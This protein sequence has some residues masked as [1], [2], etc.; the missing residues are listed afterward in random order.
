MEKKQYM[1]AGK[2]I[3]THG[4]KG[5][6]KIE[7]WLDSPEFFSSFPRLFSKGKEVKILS[8]R[9]HKGFVIARLEGIDDMNKAMEL[10]NTVVSIARTDAHLPE[11]AYFLADIIGAKVIDESGQEIGILSDIEE[12]PSSPLYVVSGGQDREEHLI[13]AVPEFIKAVDVENGV[14]TVHLIEGM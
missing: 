4:V 12:T 1:E 9:V 13:P 2:I 3:N 8:A 10:K 7:S 5:E 11:G 14:V 6:L